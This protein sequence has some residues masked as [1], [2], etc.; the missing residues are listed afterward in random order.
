[1]PALKKAFWHNRTFKDNSCPSNVN[2]SI[3]TFTLGNIKK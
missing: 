1:M 2:L 3:S